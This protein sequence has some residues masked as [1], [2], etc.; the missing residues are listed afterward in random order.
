MFNF[1]WDS[2]KPNQ[3]IEVKKLSGFK[4]ITC[5]LIIMVLIILSL[6]YYYV[7]DKSFEISYIGNWDS[8]IHSSTQLGSSIITAASKTNE[9]ELNINYVTNIQLR[10]ELSCQDI[11]SEALS[12][13]FSER[14]FHYN[15]V[16]KFSH[17][18]LKV[19]NGDFSIKIYRSNSYLFNN[20]DVCIKSGTG[21]NDR[22]E[23]DWE[24]L[25]TFWDKRYFEILV[26]ISCE[27]QTAVIITSDLNTYGYADTFS[28]CV[29]NDMD[30]L[31][32]YNL[33]HPLC[34]EAIERIK[35]PFLNILTTTQSKL[36]T[37]IQLLSYSR[38]LFLLITFM[39]K[40]LVKLRVFDKQS[41]DIS[42]FDK[43]N[44]NLDNI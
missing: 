11:I 1:I 10:D 16:R 30:Q 20:S 7:L 5:I 4:L 3:V 2:F 40:F 12:Q 36:S 26:S 27:S 38:Y 28:R 13:T 43:S 19:N 42:N 37:V 33:I 31:D 18:N 22:N 17:I 15:Q 39:M 8:T 35:P 24:G 9:T 34:V 23:N 21:W 14:T 29:I 25:Y 44:I 32:Y 6:T 41:I